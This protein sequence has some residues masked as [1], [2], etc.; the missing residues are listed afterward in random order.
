MRLERTRE[1]VLKD[2]ALLL[3]L[4]ARIHTL[5]GS[6]GDRLKMQKLSFLVCYPLFT[7]RIKGLNLT[8]FTYR[9]GPF[10][11]DLYDVEVDFEEADLIARTDKMIMVTE[12]GL[13]LAH[14]IGVSLS[15]F[16]E[17]AAIMERVDCVV[18]EY[19]GFD[20]GRLID[21]T[22]EMEV[23]PVGWQEKE[24]LDRLPLHLDLTRVLDDE[25]ANE[26]LE[27]ERSW[28]DS[29]GGIIDPS[30]EKPSYAVSSF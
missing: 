4:F 9:W 17:N 24:R 1:E 23:F 16:P 25:E 11:K 22:H 20:K 5:T 27:I 12:D 19:G 8:F 26:I 13:S 28:L 6:I 30:R 18:N 10:T 29:L 14:A 3:V 15:A 7:S 21:I 2:K